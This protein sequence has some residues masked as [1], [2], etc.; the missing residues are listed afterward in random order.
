MEAVMKRTL[1]VTMVGAFMLLQA[2]FALSE[3]EKAEPVAV[4]AEPVV[5]EAEPAA[6]KVE[7]T[8]QPTEVAKTEEPAIGKTVKVFSLRGD[9]ALDKEA[10]P[11][12]K[13]KQVKVDGGIEKNWELQPPS[14]PHDI[15]KE[16]I[17]L[18]GNTCIRCHSKENHEK[19]KAP[20]V[21]ESHYK[22]RD[23]KTLKKV[24]SRRWFCTQCHT[25]QADTKPLVENTF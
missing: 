12:K 9:L 5:V 8:E 13:M 17:T 21:A 24:S 6:V 7:A 11:I 1:L 3:D 16:T 22:T 4:E 25:A 14:I 23:G 15:S 10:N 19:E 20:A 2:P 18:K